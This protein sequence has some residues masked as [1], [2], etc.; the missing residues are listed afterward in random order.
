[1]LNQSYSN[2]KSQN[3]PSVNKKIIAAKGILKSTLQPD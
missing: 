1:M 3:L 2:L